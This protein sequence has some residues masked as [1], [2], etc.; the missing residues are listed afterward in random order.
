M[1]FRKNIQVKTLNFFLPLIPR[2]L[3]HKNK[4][5]KESDFYV[6]KDY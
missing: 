1:Y 5:K 2:F 6:G 3:L 4:F